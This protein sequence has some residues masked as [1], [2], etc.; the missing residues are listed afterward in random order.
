MR[1]AGLYRGNSSFTPAAAELQALLG[2]AHIVST[3]AI[4]PVDINGDSSVIVYSWDADKLYGSAEQKLLKDA[5]HFD[6]YV[7][8]YLNKTEQRCP[9]EF[10]AIPAVVKDQP[11]LQ[12]ATYEI[13]CVG[14]DSEAAASL[15]FYREG[16]V[17]TSVA[18]EADIGS[19]DV[20]MDVSDR[21][22]GA[23]FASK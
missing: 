22:L 8:A 14:G 9:G 7:E 20:A 12:V 2:Q 15:V 23:L 11:D 1:R 16:D 10:A 3:D 18:H 4:K 19:M 13:A 17:F 6:D 21:L 5:A